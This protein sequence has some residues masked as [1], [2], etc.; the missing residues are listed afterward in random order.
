MAALAYR[1]ALAGCGL[2]ADAN[3]QPLLFAK[4]NSSNGCVATVDVI[5]PAAPQFLL[6]GPTY[7]KALVAPALIYSTSP[8]LEVSVRPARRRRVSPG[9]WP[10]LWRR[11]ELDER[12]R[13]DA[14]RGER[15]I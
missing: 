15:A 14:G 9:Q 3:K 8:R 11:R 2:A 6:M 4:E 1:Q 13:H 10:G 5:Y 7:A 12:S